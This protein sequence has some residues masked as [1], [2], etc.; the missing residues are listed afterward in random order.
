MLPLLE[1]AI[2]L[3]ESAESNQGKWAIEVFIYWALGG[4]SASSFSLSLQ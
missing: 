3:P 1:Y 4:K 2:C